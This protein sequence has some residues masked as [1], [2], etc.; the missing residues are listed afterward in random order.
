MDGEVL[1]GQSALNRKRDEGG[2]GPG[3]AAEGS[4]TGMIVLTGHLLVHMVK[5]RPDMQLAYRRRRRA[6]ARQG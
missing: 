3:H 5:I 6:T 2:A 1:S 4:V